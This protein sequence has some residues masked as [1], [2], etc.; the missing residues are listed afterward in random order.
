MGGG[1]VVLDLSGSGQGQ[2]I[3]CLEH[4]NEP[5]SSTG[6]VECLDWL[7]NYLVSKED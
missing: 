6:R 3:G 7:R 2:V 5:S 4:D 1:W